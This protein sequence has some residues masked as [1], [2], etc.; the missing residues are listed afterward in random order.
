[1][2]TISDELKNA[3]MQSERTI[4]VRIKVGNRTFDND[5]VVSVEYDSGSLSGEVFAIGSTYSNSIKITF[6]ELVEGLKELDE[7]SYEI[8]IKLSSGAIEYV[9]MGIFIINDAIGMDRNNNKTT[10]ECMDKMVMMGGTYVSSLT[11]PAA[12]REVALE[13]AN[14]AGI[15]VDSI[16]FTRLSADKIAKPEG[17]TYRE[18]IGLI[19]Q[20]EAGF[21]TFNRYGKLEIRTLSDPNFA[22]PPDNYFSKGLVKNEVFFRLGGIS[23]T[24]DDGDTIIQSGNSAGNQVVLENRV[25]TK[26]LLDKI[27]QKIQTINY[28]PFSLSWQGNPV[29]ETGDWVEVEDLQGNKFKAPN[30]NYS[31]SFNGGLTAKS[32]AETATQSDVTYQYKSPLQQK[33]EWI[34]ARID[35]A[36]GNVVYEGIDEP[37]N[38]KEGD[39]WFKIIGPDTEILIYKK[40]SD[41]NLFWDPKISTADLKKVAE[42]VNK[43]IKQAEADRT[44]AEQDFESAKQTAKEYTDAQVIAFDTKFESET[45]AIRNEVTA[46]Y[47]NAIADGKAYTDNKSAEFNNQL[48]L[49]KA[50]VASTVLKA[51]DAVTKANKAITDA[52]FMRIDVDATKITAID[53]LTKAQTATDNVNSLTTSYDALTQ[54][55]GFKAEKIQVDAIS[56]VVAQHELEISANAQAINARLTSAQVDSLVTGKGYVNQSQLTATSS[57]WNL[58]LTKVSTDLSNLDVN[59]RNL[60]PNSGNFTSTSGWAGTTTIEQKDGFSTLKT[61]GTGY[62]STSGALQIL[63]PDTEYIV[64]A[65]FMLDAAFNATNTTPVHIYVF[66]SPSSSGTAASTGLSIVGGN[67][68]IQ[69][70]VWETVSVRFKTIDTTSPIFFKFHLFTSSSSITKW[71]KYVK[72]QKGMKYTGWSP[73]PEDQATLEQFTTIDATVKGLQTTVGNKAD[74]SQVT[75]L[76]NQWTQTTALAN[77]HTG[78]ISNLGEQINLRVVQGDVTDAI[79]ADKKIKD[80]RSTNESPAWYFANYPQQTVEEFKY[81][82]VMGVAGVEQFGQLTTKVPWSGSSGGAITQIFSSKDGVFQ[83]TSNALGTAWLAWDQVAETGKLVTQIN[84]STEG[85]LIQGKV[86]Q[87][88]GDVR[89]LQAFIDKLDVQTLNAVNANIAS[90]RTNMLTADVITST[91]IKADNAM[92]DKLFTTVAVVDYLFTKTAFVN[93]LTVKTLS[94]VT[95]N[96][97]TIRSQVLIVN[98]VQAT[99]LQADAATITKLFATDANV[100]VLT[101]KTAF[102]N[103]VQAIDISADKITAGTLNAALLNVVGMN[104]NAISTGT[105]SGANSAWNLNTGIM[106][107]TNPSSGDIMYLDQGQIKF[108]NGAQGR[109]LKY[110]A[111]GLVIEPY[112]TNTGTSRNTMLRLQGGGVGSYQYIQLESGAGISQRITGLDDKILLQHS[113][114]SGYVEITNYR[115]DTYEGKLFVGDITIKDANNDGL[116]IVNNRIESAIR[117]GSH[118]IFITPQGTGSVIVGDRGLA[119]Y[120]NI[121][122]SAFLTR[123]TRESKTNINPYFGDALSILKTITVSTFNMKQDLNKGINELKV[124]FIAEDSVPIAEKDGLGRMV[125]INTYTATAY[126]VKATQELDEKVIAINSLATATNIIATNAMNKANQTDGEVQQMKNKIIELE[127]EIKTLKGAA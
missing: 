39:L 37:S 35:A 72:V 107:F 77:G 90:I 58:A 10:I 52:G 69:P 97:T 17:Y 51:D 121:H 56:G 33:I 60:Y 3:F 38:P 14:K 81:R 85:V 24:T 124:G 4:Y 115:G 70:N 5:N 9:P 2:L 127:K 34:H 80:T 42:E 63:E 125:G 123:S 65:E 96:I 15:A 48:G 75:Q 62:P 6:S 114:N 89:M 99:H 45:G 109:N 26:T 16:S 98:V 1:M 54:T 71:V 93:N 18:A 64:T 22:I 106:S 31:L 32:S 83:R 27:Y 92:M 29:I 88:D 86:I 20:F 105:V 25:M 87:L 41:E 78:Q 103:S 57:Q 95:A 66:N 13:I 19:A 40:D 110:N 76:A 73:R 82:A 67:R 79:L 49:V 113:N 94:A 116:R 53:A 104:A 84:L 55:V 28:Y 68:V 43:I 46:G 23:C 21:A 7:V 100:N 112:S 44:K 111:E 120:W 91:H 61:L 101:A 102:I 122:A 30:L 117:S 119:N 12:I 50:D 36:G 59:D 126:L 118:N 8:G 108:Q 11:Y 74:Q 47:N